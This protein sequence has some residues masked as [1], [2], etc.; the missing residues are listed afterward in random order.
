M[1]QQERGE[2]YASNQDM[3]IA[4]STQNAVS[5]V[6]VRLSDTRWKQFA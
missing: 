6:T 3:L 5:I 4:S 1:F 2:I